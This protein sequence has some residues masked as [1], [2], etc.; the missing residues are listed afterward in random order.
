MRSD[1]TPVPLPAPGEELTV[2][3]SAEEVA[4]TVAGIAAAVDS[5]GGLTDVQRS[6]LNAHV[7]AMTDFPL[8]VSDAEPIGPQEFAEGLR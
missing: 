5:A 6:V 1:I 4:L 2:K 3:P 7:A 8:D